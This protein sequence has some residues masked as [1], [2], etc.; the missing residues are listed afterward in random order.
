MEQLIP[1][2]PLADYGQNCFVVVA[3]YYDT[4]KG[5]A[6]KHIFPSG[7]LQGKIH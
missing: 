5:K 7:S 3:R 2:C 1:E 4:L 6:F